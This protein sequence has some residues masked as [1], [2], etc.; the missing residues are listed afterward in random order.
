MPQDTT[1]TPEGEPDPIISHSLS[2]PIM[3]SAILLILALA[4]ALYAEVWGDRPWKAYQ[5][6]FVQTYTRYLKSVEPAQ[7][8]T[9]KQLRESPDAQSLEQQ[10][11]AAEAGAAEILKAIDRELSGVRQRLSAIEKPFEDARAKV[12]ALEYQLDHAATPQGK[13]SIR[14]AIEQARR[15]GD[16]DHLQQSFNALKQ[17]EAELVAK[18]A[19]ATKPAEDVRAR[20]NEFLR[21]N[22][23]GASPA[24]IDGLL[25]KLDGFE[26]GIRQIYVEDSGLVDRCESCHLGIREPVQLTAADTGG[27]RVFVSHPK[28]ELLDIHDPARFGC[29]PCHNGNGVAV[30]SVKE[31]HGNYPHWQWPMFAP[32]DRESGCQQCHVRDRVLEDAPTLSRGKDLFQL[33]GCAGCHRFEGFDREADAL[34][35]TRRQVRSLTRQQEQDRI[36]RDIETKQGDQAESNEETKKHYAAADALLLKASQ[37]DAKLDALEGTVRSIQRDVKKAG[38]NLKDARLKLR[39]EWIPQWLADPRS[40]NPFPRM[41]RFRLPDS[42]VR[43]LAAFIW[44]TA[45]D[46]PRPEQQKSGEAAH[47]KELFETRGCLACHSIGE[48]A[49][50]MGGESAANLTRIG[51]KASYDYIVRWV[52]DPRRRTRPFCPL[53]QRDL[54]PE[55]YARH[56]QPWVF[57]ENHSKCPNDGTELQIQNMTVMPS[58]RLTLQEA[59]DI[60]TYLTGLSHPSAN[61]A[62]VRYMDDPKLAVAGR[63][64]VS[65]YGCANCHEI[66]GF[67]D[68]RQ[69]ATE[70]TTWASKPIEQL[71][72]GLLEGPAKHDGWY[73]TKGFIEH[74]LQNPA[75]YDTNREKA[76]QDRLKMPAID[77][78]AEDLRALTTFMLGSLDTSTHG[79]FRTIPDSL[80]YNPEGAKK[81]I[82]DGWW[83]IKK[84]NCMGCHSIQIGQSS[85]LS[86]LPLYADPDT[87]DQLPPSLIEEGARVSPA[88]LA[89]FLAN[90][91]LDEERS[92]GNGVRTYLRARMPTFRFSQNEINVLVRFFEAISGQSAAATQARIE[93]LDD[94]ERQVARALFSAPGAP[95]LQCHLYGDPNHDRQASAP[96]FL[97]AKD[98][99]KPGWT[100]RWILDPQTISPGTAMPSQLFRRNGDRW[101]LAGQIPKDAQS[102]PGDHAQLLVRYMLSMTTDEQRRLVG[103]MPRTPS[104]RGAK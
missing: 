28:R 37:I 63:A 64:L 23:T 6:R 56:G 99:L 95:C 39:K 42:E 72:F 7:A 96:N 2:G 102:Y 71:D 67:E 45:W 53:E 40:V 38:P 44:Q 57:D 18:H 31:A 59:Q 16:L 24:Q 21:R 20:L 104:A 93:P 51:E 41:P 60:A 70:L 68:A 27:Q 25:R 100:L 26:V 85:V 52:Q 66:Q 86:G 35:E 11:K 89:Q 30:S 47:G 34:A 76:P 83:L 87:K 5:R 94:R 12:A 88:W 80:R 43:A 13:A 81:D 36:D 75:I 84:Y 69:S 101:V 48:G 9:E 54:T 1:P 32:A 74:K 92:E 62:D 82:Q 58:L 50:R 33:K 29:T 10:I 90:P 19:A 77:L 15:E 55:D 79:E 46:G 65:R 4:W 8:A 97:E 98:R 73:S 3:V 17:R 78:S 61:P 49:G 91:A 22:R 103:M 14:S